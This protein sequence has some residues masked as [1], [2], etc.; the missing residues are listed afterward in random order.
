MCRLV[1]F[2][3]ACVK[4]GGDFHWHELT[5]QLPC[6]ESKNIGIFGECR[7]GVQVDQHTFD[8]ECDDCLAQEDEG[9]AEAE[10]HHRKRKDSGRDKKRQRTS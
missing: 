4:C 2:A 10:E 8:Q 9:Y 6:L 3:G 5:Q 1:M 7:N